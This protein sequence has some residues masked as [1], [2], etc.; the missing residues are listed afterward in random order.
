[1]TAPPRTTIVDDDTDMIIEEVVDV[2][3][4]GDDVDDE[5]E[6]DDDD[7][8]GGD[9]SLVAD[10]LVTAEGEGVADVLG[11]IRDKLDKI[12][13]VLFKMSQ[14]QQPPQP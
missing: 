7:D 10:A 12:S 8:L 3:D 9:L 6:Y 4:D 1:M 11:S 5:S 2:V 13:R 14:Q